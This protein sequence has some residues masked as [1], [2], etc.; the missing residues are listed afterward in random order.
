[1]SGVDQSWSDFWLSVT[2]LGDGRRRAVIGLT[3]AAWLGWRFGARPALVLLS[4]AA[5]ETVA[6]AALKLGFARDR[7]DLI[8]R[9]DVVTSL[10]YPSG[11]AAHTAALFVLA[12]LLARD[13]SGRGWPLLLGIAATLLIGVSR[14]VL[15]VHWP[16]DV[17]GGWLL[18]TGFA[19]IG[20][21]AARRPGGAEPEQ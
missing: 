17:L 9:L 4:T 5:V 3:I 20:W 11:H 1:M 19:L 18:G 13:L 2:W 6:G 10:A 12:G 7:P 8:E 15:G 16:S 14:V 21:A